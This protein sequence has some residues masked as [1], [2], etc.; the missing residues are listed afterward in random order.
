MGVGS[1]VIAALLHGRAGYGCI[2]QAYHANECRP[3]PMGRRREKV[4]RDVAALFRWMRTHRER[5]KKGQLLTVSNSV[6]G[7]ILGN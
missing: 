5:T 7:G 3:L 4:E 6:P 1:S 2:E